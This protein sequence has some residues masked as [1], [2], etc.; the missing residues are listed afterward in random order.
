MKIGVFDSGKGGVF[1]AQRLERH[2]PQHTYTVIND[3]K[4]IPY[5]NKSSAVIQQ[6][7][8][9]AIQPLLGNCPIIVIACNT[10][11][12][13]AIDWLRQKYPATYF[14]GYEPMIKPAAT[15]TISGRITILATTATVQSER[16]QHLKHM[17]GSATNIDE[18]L[19]HDWAKFIEEDHPL[20]IILDE[21]DTSVQKG[22]DV[23]ALACT[24]YLALEDRLR[25]RYPHLHIIEPT[26]AVVK[27]IIILTTQLQPQT[28]HH[29]QN[30]S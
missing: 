18:P 14:V 5:G 4:N 3:H 21:V 30:N 26:P 6:L 23:I 17:H 25:S 12:A 9:R 20:D 19:T 28:A 8:D 13:H 16:Y 11:T 7:T 10:A 27:R 29:D 22:S 2:M 24:H 1:V 15:L